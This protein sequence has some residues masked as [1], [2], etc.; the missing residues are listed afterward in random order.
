MIHTD[1]VRGCIFPSGKKSKMGFE[2]QL[3][4][5]YSLTYMS[6]WSTS[7]VSTT[8]RGKL[9]VDIFPSIT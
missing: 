9:D 3:C 5:F 4:L 8:I 7:N 6:M 2:Q 1:N